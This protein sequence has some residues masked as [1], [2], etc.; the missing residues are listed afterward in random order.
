MKKS[1]HP[2]KQ[3]KSHKLLNN[4]I[5]IGSIRDSFLKADI[6][7]K[8]TTVIIDIDGFS[9]AFDAMMWARLQSELWLKEMGQYEPKRN[10]TLH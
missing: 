5:K 4:G 9:N 1:K 7:V 3:L 6:R 2:K 8:D 10:I